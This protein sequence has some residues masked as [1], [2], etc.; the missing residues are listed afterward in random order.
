MNKEK[1]KTKLE[2]IAQE[3]AILNQIDHPNI[4]KYFETYDDVKYIYLVM[5]Y[6]SGEQLLKKVI[7]AEN[8]YFSED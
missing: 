4:V 6:I 2:Y 1:M 5:E 3:L 8:N 7:S